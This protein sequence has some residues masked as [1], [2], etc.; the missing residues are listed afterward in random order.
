MAKPYEQKA[1]TEHP[2]AHLTTW[3]VR[4][5]N[6]GEGDAPLGT[7]YDNEGE[8]ERAAEEHNAQFTPPHYSS[9]REYFP[10]PYDPDIPDFR[11]E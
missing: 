6:E 1:Q 10:D 3:E 4:C 9:V 7:V 11:S 8:A 2:S 5:P